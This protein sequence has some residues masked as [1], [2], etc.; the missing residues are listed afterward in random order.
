M[1]TRVLI[2]FMTLGMM[3][4]ITGCGHEHQWRKATCE[5]PKTCVT[6]GETEGK[7]LKHSWVEATYEEAKHCEECGKTKGEP[8]KEEVEEIEQAETEEM[9]TEAVTT[10]VEND[11]ITESEDKIIQELLIAEKQD[12]GYVELYLER[13]FELK[14]TDMADQFL[15]VDVDGND[16]PEL[17]ASHSSGT[18]SEDNTFLYT[19]YD[20]SVVLLECGTSGMDGCSIEFSEGN[21]VIARRYG[22]VGEEYIYSKLNQGQLE[23]IFSTSTG[24]MY[25]EEVGDTVH[26][27]GINGN[28]VSK[29]E[30]Y[31][32]IA[33]F[34][35]SY[36]PFTRID[37]EGL[38]TIDISYSDGYI[39]YERT[40]KQE[41]MTYDEIRTELKNK[42]P[43]TEFSAIEEVYTDVDMN[44]FIHVLGYMNYHIGSM[45]NPERSAYR[46][47]N[48]YH[49]NIEELGWGNSQDFIKELLP[50]AMFISQEEG[51]ALYEVEASDLIDFYWEG[52]GKETTVDLLLAENSYGIHD[53]GNGKLH[54]E[55]NTMSA[56]V[57][58]HNT[59]ESVTESGNIVQV[60]GE[61]EFFDGYDLG[62]K[63]VCV[64]EKNEASTLNGYRILDVK[65]E[66]FI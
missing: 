12:L 39:N 18:F 15:L 41:Y 24:G 58:Y 26:Y 16:I 10:E 66:R 35:M 64:L 36:Y 45:G 5:R 60:S 13:I 8:L 23:E 47:L 56:P 21:N 9:V 49:F 53:V 62:Y 40:Y 29:E 2:L 52:F 33:D 63:Y 6:C 59:I 48:T 20:N 38:W 54:L 34:A 31:D 27:W 25:N 7:K 19:V 37:Y 65:V 61:C 11:V 43:V 22:L 30:Y 51:Y 44:E 32:Q 55:L 4:G 1:K 28:G 14:S 50:S 46:F 17:A 3:I 42:L 57:D